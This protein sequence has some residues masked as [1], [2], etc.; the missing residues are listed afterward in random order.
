MTGQIYQKPA[1]MADDMGEV[2][3][4][5]DERLR[6]IFEML[7]CAALPSGSSVLDV[8]MG[9]GQIADFF[10]AR[11]MRVTGTGLE[12]SSYGADLDALRNRGVRTVECSVEHMPFEENSF[13]AVV[14]SHTLEHCPNVGI[15]LQEVRRVLK[16]G[17]IL[18][19]FVPPHENT[20]CAG[21][22]SVGWN[23]GQLMYV[24]LLNGFE[25]K[26]GMF[27]EFGYN[28]GG[29]V[30]KTTELLP[31]LRCD[32]GDIHILRDRFPLAIPERNGLNDNFFGKLVTVNW[33]A[34]APTSPRRSAKVVLVEA[35]LA[36]LPES[37]LVA[38]A[39]FLC[40]VGNRMLE[41]L[42]ARK[43]DPQAKL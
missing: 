18:M 11:G 36:R 27:R 6:T 2:A 22:I 4:A 13:D 7:E 40:R 31:P 29:F 1:G 17:G 28:V 16:V 39:N 25:V 37:R 42:S 19:I 20:V 34:T 24:L 14:M 5:P 43:Q 3:G 21:H 15:A 10:T 32:R 30:K 12:I 9:K 33:P 41:Y 23:I 35:I 26:T 8:G 38:A